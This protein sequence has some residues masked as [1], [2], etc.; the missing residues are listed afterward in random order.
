MKNCLK[1]SLTLIRKTVF[2]REMLIFMFAIIFTFVVLLVSAVKIKLKDYETMAGILK[3]NGVMIRSLALSKAAEDGGTL[4]RDEEELAEYLGDTADILCMEQVWET[5]VNGEKVETYCY[6]K[7]VTQLLAPEM[8]SGR[9]LLDEDKND[10]VLKVVV[11]YNDGLFC[12]GDRI[13]LKCSMDDTLEQE[14]EVIGVLA[15]NQLMFMGDIYRE[16]YS[17]YRDCFRGLSSE[18]DD[19]IKL[20]ISDEQLE[21]G[22]FPYL[23]FRTGPDRGFQKQ[24][25][26]ITVVTFQDHVSDED[27]QRKLDRLRSLSHFIGYNTLADVNQNSISYVTAELSTWIPM[28][29]M[30]IVFVLISLIS[31]NI[32]MTRRM[33]GYYAVHYLCGFTWKQNA[34]VTLLASAI[35]SA[36]AFVL[37]LLISLT[38]TTI[39]SMGVTEA[40]ACL[41]AAGVIIFTAHISVL[42]LIGKT[43]AKEILSENGHRRLVW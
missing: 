5:K 43:S 37:V 31:V 7:K 36:V 24:M 29:V 16:Q 19:V 39:L 27:I 14:L 17:D 2:I 18:H 1:L 23:N 42:I 22:A 11:S 32:V 3:Q 10:D 4:L 34:N 35:E 13:A 6:S 38:K 21:T 9:W 15:D 40:V 33:M 20:F 26:D 30:L 28:F 41:I 8:E 12:V 25:R